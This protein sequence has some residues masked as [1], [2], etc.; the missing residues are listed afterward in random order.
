MD[1][2]D[3]KK[4][5]DKYNIKSL[6][7]L[8]EQ[9]E[10]YAD[11]LDPHYDDCGDDPLDKDCTNSNCYEDFFVPDCRKL[12][13]LYNKYFKKEIINRRH[14]IAYMV[15]NTNKKQSSIENYM[16][17]RS[18][19]QQ[20][21]KGTQASLKI[22]DSEFKKDFCN[23]LSI[24]FCYSSIFETDYAS[25]K[26][27]LNKEHEIT[28]DSFEP[29]FVKK[30]VGM[31]KD[32]KKKLFDLTH[33]SKQELKSNLAIMSN[34]DGSNDYKMNLALAAFDRNLIEESYMLVELLSK[35][36]GFSSNILLRQLKAKILS[37]K[38]MDKEAIVLLKSLREQ[39][40]AE[41]DTETNS[42]L[43]A[44]IKREAFS[45][46]EIYADEDVLINKLEEA[47]DIYF[48]IYQLNHDYY[49]ALNYMYIVSMLS[50]INGDSKSEENKKDF[51]NI[52]D[53]V[54]HVVTDW[55]SYVAE[56]EFLIILEEYQ[57]AE[58]KLKAHFDE[59]EDI[60]VSDFNVSSTTRQLKLYSNFYDSND[61]KEIIAFLE[62]IEK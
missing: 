10:Y 24:K 55:W 56:V 47:R 49:P 59:L 19:N 34:L 36:E 44:S 42:L 3:I 37:N 45:D 29:I 9:L 5:L 57:L 60:E 4:L 11:V 22:S 18:C 27:F 54:N 12:I 50:H 17:C 23:N 52:W 26:Q 20:L 41:I 40:G 61:L 15:Q 46:Y 43:A 8:E 62:N 38:Q 35:E 53:T 2:N 28:S 21:R 25:I 13:E 58:E 32:E 30:E 39:T 48:S 1:V 33:V 51:R 14:F 6:S 16:Y 31:T 7:K